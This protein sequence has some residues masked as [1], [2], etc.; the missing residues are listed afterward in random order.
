M[1]KKNAFN[2][3]LVVRECLERP[4]SRARSSDQ[5]DCSSYASRRVASCGADELSCSAVTRPSVRR[6]TDRCVLADGK[7]VSRGCRP[8]IELQKNK[9]GGPLCPSFPQQHGSY[10]DGVMKISEGAR[11]TLASM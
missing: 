11:H 1:G 9:Y 2:Y 6:V 7:T 5:R 3:R 10:G 4:G 8:V